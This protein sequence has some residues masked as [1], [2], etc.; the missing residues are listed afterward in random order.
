M[1]RSTVA[2]LLLVKI[3]PLLKGRGKNKNCRKRDVVARGEAHESEGVEEIENPLSCSSGS[4]SKH[5]RNV[6]Y[7]HNSFVQ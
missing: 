2:I 3:C 1:Q 5:A 4:R 6:L 7:L